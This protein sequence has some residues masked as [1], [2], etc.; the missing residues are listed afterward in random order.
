MERSGVPG[1]KVGIEL[2]GE[3]R[4]SLKNSTNSKK[5]KRLNSRALQLDKV[6]PA[7]GVID[8]SGPTNRNG[9]VPDFVSIHSI[10]N[11]N[12]EEYLSVRPVSGAIQAFRQLTGRGLRLSIVSRIDPE[13]VWVETR[14]RKWNAQYGID[15]T[16]PPHRVYFCYEWCEKKIFCELIKPRFV[17]DDRL[18]VLTHLVGIVPHRF[19]FRPGSHDPHLWH[20]V[21]TRQVYWVD[22]WGEVMEIL[23]KVL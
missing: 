23:D 13:P 22:S 9:A 15:E 19:L 21:E 14:V 20:L 6:E 12:S 1:Q 16:I 11:P 18:A 10:G 8:W 17:V 4:F 2:G 5:G 3:N 7:D